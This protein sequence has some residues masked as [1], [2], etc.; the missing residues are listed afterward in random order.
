MPL[1][2]PAERDVLTVLN[3]ASESVSK[4]LDVFWSTYT[5]HDKDNNGYLDISEMSRFFKDLFKVRRGGVVAVAQV[6]HKQWL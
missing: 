6:A 1:L 5:A 3:T 4:G 2:R